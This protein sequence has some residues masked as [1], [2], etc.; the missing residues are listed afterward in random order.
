MITDNVNLISIKKILF[1]EKNENERTLKIKNSLIESKVLR[2]P[3]MAVSL[4]ND[5]YMLID[6]AN[7]AHALIEL[8]FQYLP[9]FVLSENDLKVDTWAH[10]LKSIETIKNYIEKDDRLMMDNQKC[11]RYI[12]KIYF[13]N[14][15]YIIKFSNSCEYNVKNIISIWHDL[16]ILYKGKSIRRLERD[17]NETKI[18]YPELTINQINEMTLQGIKIP[19]G[20]TRFKSKTGRILN[21]DIPLYLINDDSRKEFDNYME[22]VGHS[23]RLY[24]ESVYILE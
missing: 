16:V 12:A 9:V 5:S 7:R 8:G 22:Q 2:T 20:I 24:E 1:H 13:E 17:S 11:S 6:G 23:L 18:V 19:T 4:V 15:P 3:L 14:K 10:Q 21:I